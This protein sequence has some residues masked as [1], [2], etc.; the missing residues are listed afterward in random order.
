VDLVNF[1]SLELI[2]LS[3]GISNAPHELLLDP[4]IEFVRS[5]AYKFVAE[6][7]PSSGRQPVRDYRG[8]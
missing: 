2:S 8:V 3:E 7:M 5:K 4:F 6:A 1:T